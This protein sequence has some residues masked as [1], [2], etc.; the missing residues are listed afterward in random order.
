MSLWSC[1]EE[2]GIN[3]QW[4][5]AVVRIDWR[6]VMALL[7]SGQGED[8]NEIRHG[9]TILY[10]A[11]LDREIV[12]IAALLRHGS[13]SASTTRDECVEPLLLSSTSVL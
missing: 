2:A 7:E 3:D 4:G 1:N 6:R 8:V 10:Q 12:A 13:A 11:V 9:R 5:K